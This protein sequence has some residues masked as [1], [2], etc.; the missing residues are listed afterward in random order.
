MAGCF[1][2]I[3]GTLP[4]PDNSMRNVWNILPNDTRDKMST[5]LKAGAVFPSA[6]PPTTMDTDFA[7]IDGSSPRARSDNIGLELIYETRSPTPDTAAF[8]V[9]LGTCVTDDVLSNPASEAC[10]FKVDEQ[11]LLEN[12]KPL[13]SASSPS[14]EDYS[15]LSDA[16]S[17]QSESLVFSREFEEIVKDK[18][19]EIRVRGV[20][21]VAQSLLATGAQTAQSAPVVSMVVQVML[22]KMAKGSVTQAESF[23]KALRVGA[24]EVF[25]RHWKLVGFSFAF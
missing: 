11:A 20:D 21:F 7:V 14:N 23:K 3:T 13:E 16:E 25:R 10:S 18:I 9:A 17:G 5:P 12:D 1:A 6:P 4:L 15:C 8:G 2:N 22:C 19:E 24:S